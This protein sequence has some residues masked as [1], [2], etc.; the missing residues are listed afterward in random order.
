MSEEEWE[1]LCAHC[2]KCCLCKYQV[3]SQT[4]FT[5]ACCS[6][7]DIKTC[8]C[9]IYDKRLQSGSC[10]KVNLKLLR[11]APYLLPES[12]AYKRL[13][14]HQPLPLWHPLLTHTQNSVAAAGQSVSSLPLIPE[15]VAEKNP[16]LLKIIETIAD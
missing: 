12:C 9:R 2:G 6:H 10:V 13:Y 5:N 3:G 7:L 4:V 11:E 1:A 8:R 14:N 15:Y 16:L